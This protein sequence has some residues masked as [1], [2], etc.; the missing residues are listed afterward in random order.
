[1]NLAEWIFKLVKTGWHVITELHTILWLLGL[2]GITGVPVWLGRDTLQ[3]P[4]VSFGIGVLTW[5]IL[6]VCVLAYYG[7][8]AQGPKLQ[9]T[10]SSPQPTPEFISMKEA[11]TRL[12]ES[13]AN[14]TGIPL[15]E[16]AEKLGGRDLGAAS[17]NERLEYLATFLSGK[18]AV[19]GRKPPD[20]Q[21]KQIDSAEVKRA[22]FSDGATML[23]DK[24]YDKTIYWEDLCVKAHD[25]NDFIARLT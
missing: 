6:F 1:M 15:R 13:S 22:F 19:F 7:H 23:R 8:K 12:Y 10:F 25:L 21:L 24:T 11:A 18:I 5:A 14:F 3:N 16:A 2:A 4:A 17:P 9:H 20:R